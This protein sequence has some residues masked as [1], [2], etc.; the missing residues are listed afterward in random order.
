MSTMESSMPS[1]DGAR[2]HG[3]E[4]LGPALRVAVADGEAVDAAQPVAG[5]VEHE[6]VLLAGHLVAACDE[7]V[8]DRG[9]ARRVGLRRMRVGRVVGSIC[10]GS[11]CAEHRRRLFFGHWLHEGR[12][13][14]VGVHC[15]ARLRAKGAGG[16]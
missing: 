13:P 11:I 1:L 15:P 14:L 9:R 3:R 8:E 2:L 7:L 12:R 16:A 6:F 4:G 5:H 10:P